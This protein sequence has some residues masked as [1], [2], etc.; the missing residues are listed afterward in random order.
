MAMEHDN[1]PCMDT[2]PLNR[3][4]GLIGGKWRCRYSVP[5]TTT[6]PPATIS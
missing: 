5:S 2:C 6:A 4:M 3:A 1:C